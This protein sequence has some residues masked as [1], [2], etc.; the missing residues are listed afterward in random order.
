M[1]FKEQRHESV[2][3]FDLDHTLLKVNVSYRFGIYLYRKKVL[4]MLTMLYLLL[5]YCCHQLRLIS[6]TYLYQQASSHLFTGKS[7]KKITSLVHSYLEDEWN[8]LPNPSVVSKLREAQARGDYTVIL[9]SSPSF[10][11]KNIANRF[12]VHAWGAT[13]Y[14]VLNND[15]L[16]EVTT[17]MHGKDKAIYVEK[18]IQQLGVSK[19]NITAYTDSHLDLPFLEAVGHPVGVNPDRR[20]RKVCEENQWQV[21][22]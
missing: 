19:K 7:Y 3:I 13:E 21:I 1:N 22:Q 14:S 12:D 20:L 18:L 5:F 15:T 17:T 10:L 16:G 9:S 4:P 8:Q 2:S 11:V 6:T